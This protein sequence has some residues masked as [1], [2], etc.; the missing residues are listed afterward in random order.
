MELENKVVN[1]LKR[2]LEKNKLLEILR[3]LIYGML[4]RNNRIER[5]RKNLMGI[6]IRIVMKKLRLIKG[7]KRKILLIIKKR[8]ILQKIRFQKKMDFNY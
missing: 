4:M 8:K 2:N 5:I 1:L 7:V 3:N 6:S